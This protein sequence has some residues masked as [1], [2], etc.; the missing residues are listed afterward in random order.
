M[1]NNT[2]NKQLLLGIGLIICGTCITSLSPIIVYLDT[3]SAIMSSFYRLFFGAIVLCAILVFN[4]DLKFKLSK[5][6]KLMLIA[7][8]C[9]TLDI[10]IWYYCMDYIGPGLSTLIISTEAIG[11]GIVNQWVKKKKTIFTYE[12]FSMPKGQRIM[13]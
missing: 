4:K 13:I 10:V 12:E 5:P 6:P 9:L 1:Q 3:V 2:I 7:G 11:V 8:F